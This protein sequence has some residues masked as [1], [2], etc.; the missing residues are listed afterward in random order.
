M[1]TANE[2]P[3]ALVN[4][5]SESEGSECEEGNK[6]LQ[7]STPGW[8]RPS[9]LVG[10][11]GAERWDECFAQSV[12]VPRDGHSVVN[13]SAAGSV[14]YGCSAMACQLHAAGQDPPCAVWRGV[15][16][17]MLRWLF[18]DAGPPWIVSD[19]R[20][21]GVQTEQTTM[22]VSILYLFAL[23][24]RS[25]ACTGHHISLDARWFLARMYVQ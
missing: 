15:K 7:K 5:G 17:R 14:Q 16:L 23:S 4:G 22:P 2:A 6:H 8:E 18:L 24:I 12:L 11:S 20:L 3:R 1:E 19:T 21:G 25:H 13:S 9:M 10:A